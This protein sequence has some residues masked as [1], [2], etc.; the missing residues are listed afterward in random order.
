MVGKYSGGDDATKTDYYIYVFH[1]P[2]FQYV[3]MY[4]LD[5]PWPK[6]IAGSQ[7]DKHPEADYREWIESHWLHS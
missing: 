7:A 5:S 2:G 6:A 1:N 3:G 4:W